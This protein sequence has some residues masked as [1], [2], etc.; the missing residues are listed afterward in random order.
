M[1]HGREQE[2]GGRAGRTLHVVETRPPGSL[3]MEND[4]HGRAGVRSCVIWFPW[5]ADTKM[6][7]GTSKRGS[8]MKK[9]WAESR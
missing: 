5:E 2:E 1:L 7:L 4:D 3:D 6:K 8:L 9:D